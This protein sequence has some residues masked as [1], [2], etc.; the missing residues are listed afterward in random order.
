MV[1]DHKNDLPVQ[2]VGKSLQTELQK[3]ID[4]KGVAR[5]D[6]D[7][8]DADIVVS[9]NLV[10]GALLV[11]KTIAYCDCALCVRVVNCCQPHAGSGTILRILKL[12]FRPSNHA[13][14]WTLL[15]PMG[16]LS[17]TAQFVF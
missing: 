14:P 13:H 5:G 15:G 12:S 11:C 6:K 4:Q 7:S 17:N 1:L 16:A 2:E 10:T 8:H 3:F 9:F